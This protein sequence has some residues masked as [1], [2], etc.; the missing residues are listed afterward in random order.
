ME[1]KPTIIITGA[2]G[3]VGNE[4]LRFFHSKNFKIIVLAREIPSTKL[5]NVSY[6]N[7]DLAKPINETINFKNSVVIH[8]AYS[9][10]NTLQNTDVN[11]LALNNILSKVKN[12][13]TAHL[14]FLSSI[15]INF[16]SNTYYAR[17]KKKSEEILNSFNCSILRLG[18]VVGK[19]GLFYKTVKFIKKFRILPFV[20]GGKQPIYYVFVQ[21]VLNCIEQIINN[22][23]FGTF[24]L[25]NQNPLEYKIFYKLIA[26]KINVKIICINIPFW[27]IK[28][29][30]T[31]F[32]FALKNYFTM[33]SLNGLKKASTINTEQIVNQNFDYN[34]KNLGE[35]K[36]ADL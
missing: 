5:N 33:D 15:A 29:T 30:Y 32:S 36:P 24:F 35:L 34:F 27:L 17:Q 11:E 6:Y 3:F 28:F 20:N 8:C 22:K 23:T 9:K 16:N 31:L 14:I 19:G 12:E 18:L 21:D 4:I 26:E 13:T 1:N 25:F 2:T 7:Y 10:N